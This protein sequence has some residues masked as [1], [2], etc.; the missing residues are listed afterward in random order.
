MP[1]RQSR[2]DVIGLNSQPTSCGWAA[3]DWEQNWRAIVESRRETI[4]G[5][6]QAFGHGTQFWDR[7]AA[8][9]RRMSEQH[10]PDRDLLVA[11]LKEPLHAGG[12]F[13]DIGAGAGRYT[14]PIAAMAQRVTAVEPSGAMRQHLE[15]RLTTARLTNVTILPVSWEDAVVEPH[16][17]VLA[18]HVV[19]PIADIVPFVQKLIAHARHTWFI[20]I[21]VQPMGIEFAPLWEQIWHTPYP[22]EPTFLDLYNLLFSL[23]LR[24]HARLKPFAGGL[25]AVSLD[26]AVAQARSRLFLAE[27]DTQHDDHI[28]RYLTTHM[29][30][31]ED[32]RWR[33]PA[34][35]QEAVIYGSVDL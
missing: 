17:V 18:A 3:Q 2:E 6:G 23:G 28:R 25:G 29:R 13:L 32:G 27:D 22:T 31:E 11:L 12:S 8:Q 9:F 16:D 21:R 1:K 15:E 19:Y 5:L 4:E 7:R 20:T 24:P 33:W 30:L 35:N 26:D 14:L 34:R 10:D